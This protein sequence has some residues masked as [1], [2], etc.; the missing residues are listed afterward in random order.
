MPEEYETQTLTFNQ[1]VSA[2]AR[3]VYH[4]F[5][6]ATALRE[7]LCDAAMAHPY[8]GG[9]MYMWFN[10]GFYTSGE[11]ATLVA[12][13]EVVFTWRGRAE[14][15]ATLVQVSLDEG[16]GFTNVRLSHSGVGFDDSWEQ[17]VQELRRLWERRLENLAAVME[18]GMDQRF[19]NR[20][21]LGITLD[22]FNSEIARELGVP[23][24]EGMRLDGV[25]GGMG[26]EKAGL[27]RDDVIV[28]MGGLPVARWADLSHAIQEHQAGDR[29][30]VIFYRGPERRT[31][32]MELSRRP[33][34]EV[35]GRPAE[36][37]EAVRKGADEV[38]EELTRLF[39]GVTEQQASWK[40]AQDE[41]SAKENVAH[42]IHE[43]RENHV[44]IPD[45]V[46]S[47]ERWSDDFISNSHARVAATVQAYPTIPE[48]LEHLKRIMVETQALV[49]NLP[50]E[51]VARKPSYWRMGY[52]LLE[53]ITHPRTHFEQIRSTLEAAR[54][55]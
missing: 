25:V 51:F 29:L 55:A 27:Q 14:P 24:K 22:E 28:A 31:V 3:Q 42:L 44:W 40:P 10:G 19:V 50:E 30:E 7:W 4:A 15:A 41:W 52:N 35:P 17:P 9:R 38:Y 34:P 36:L 18:T 39:E 1:K 32:N 53:S 43:E 20:P 23:V 47:Q 5:T 33:L 48:L 2:P 49:T 21:M 26:A 37:A 8:P 16:K 11:Y 54:Q 45:L 46:D 12:D 13:K 6:N